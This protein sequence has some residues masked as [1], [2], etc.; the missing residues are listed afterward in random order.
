MQSKKNK[1]LAVKKSL[2]QNI[3]D[4]DKVLKKE[5]VTNEYIKYLNTKY[6]DNFSNLQRLREKKLTVIENLN[7]KLSNG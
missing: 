2:E 5:L 1:R 6:R 4:I 3:S 7:K